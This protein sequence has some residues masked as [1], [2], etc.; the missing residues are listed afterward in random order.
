MKPNKYVELT[1]AWGDMISNRSYVF[2]I[3]ANDPVDVMKEV[4]K[5]VNLDADE[6]IIGYKIDT[7][8]KVAI[9]TSMEETVISEDRVNYEVS[10]GLKC[11]ILTSLYPEEKYKIVEKTIYQTSFTNYETAVSFLK[12]ARANLKEEAY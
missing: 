9:V 8:E 10:A 11:Y 7:I 4:K 6:H 1:I 3:E 5:R 12:G 2:C